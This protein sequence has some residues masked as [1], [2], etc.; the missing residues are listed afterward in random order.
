MDK[1]LKLVIDC[2]ERNYAPAGQTRRHS[3]TLLTNHAY[4]LAEQF[5]D[6]WL[7]ALRVAKRSGQTA[8][9]KDKCTRFILRVCFGVKFDRFR[10]II[11]LNDARDPLEFSR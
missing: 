5:V 4:E 6:N 1:L 11:P 3:A 9:I 10:Q 8:E 2:V 7:I